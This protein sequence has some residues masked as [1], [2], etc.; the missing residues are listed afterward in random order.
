VTDPTAEPGE[1]HGEPGVLIVLEG[2]DRSGRSTHA[3]LLEE[4][5]RYAGLGV[6][7]TSLAS[8][9]L[10][11]GLIR[12]AKRDRTADPVEIAL[13]YAADLAERLDQVIAPSLRAGLVVIAD[14]YRWT[15]MARAE[16]RGVDAAW[17]GA[18][19]DFVPRPDAVLYL[20]IDPDAS[21]ARRSSEPDP[22]E[23]GADLGLSAD[24][25]KSYRLFQARLADCFERCAAP[26]GFTRIAAAGSVPVVG[27]RVIRAA[28]KAI[29]TRLA[30]PAAPR[31]VTARP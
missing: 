25:R 17:L 1:G 3:R 23:A 18:L 14:R 10:T 15:P 16:A 28:D 26:A 8:A 13:L 19:F 21:L 2:I 27:R 9:T 20:D 22:F 5:L 31:P 12:T 7:R 24:R 11:G 4:H 29:A 6:A 30:G